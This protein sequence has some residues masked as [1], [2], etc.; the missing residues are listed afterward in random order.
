MRR[1]NETCPSL[2][3]LRGVPPWHTPAQR[4]DSGK[5]LGESSS[6]VAPGQGAKPGSQYKAL[7]SWGGVGGG[8]EEGDRR[9]PIQG[10][11]GAANKE[12]VG[13]KDA[14]FSPFLLGRGASRELRTR[15]SAISPP[16]PPAPQGEDLTE[17]LSWGGC[18]RSRKRL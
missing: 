7:A 14:G 15:T 8:V 9:I 17:A 13:R 4:A 12:G 18:A 16:P 6:A 11:V 1:H 10:R 2:G 5:K 3:Y